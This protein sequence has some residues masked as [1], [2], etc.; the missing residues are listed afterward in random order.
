MDINTHKFRVSM[1]YSTLALGALCLMIVVYGFSK[2]T[3]DSV[4]GRLLPKHVRGQIP[5]VT[6]SAA[7][8]MS[9]TAIP[10]NTNTI[11]HIPEEIP[12]ITRR[13]LFGRKGETVRYWGYCFPHNLEESAHNRRR[14]FPG[15]LFLSEAERAARKEKLVTERRRT[16]SV[17]QNLTERDLNETRRKPS[18]HIRHQL[19]IFE[20]GTTCYVMSNKDISIGS[21]VD[22]DGLHAGLERGYGSDPRVADTDADGVNDGLEVFRAH[23]HPTKR[24]SDGDGIVDGIEDANRNG[25]FDPGETSPTKWDTDRDGLCDGLCK[26]NKGQDLRGEDRNLNGIYEEGEGEYDPRRMDSDGDGI[27][28]DHEVYLCVIGGGTDC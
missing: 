19:E 28:D 9:G 11:I 15:Q 8:V 6:I 13:V 14:G 23:S 21:D 26:V 18:N 16:F 4:E 10:A 5:W 25:L 12:R 27:N 22:G 3:G 2:H 7:R 24:D 1:Q 20:G 17:F